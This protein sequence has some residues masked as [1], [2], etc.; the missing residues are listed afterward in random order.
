MLVDS[1]CQAYHWSFSD[2]LKLT[3]PQIVML[4]HAAWVNAE[5]A[6]LHKHD[7]RQGRPSKSAL[8]DEE[9]PVITSGKRMSELTSDEIFGYFNQQD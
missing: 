3:M 4:N 8:R 9:D 2:A 6:G 5:K 7:D 1:F